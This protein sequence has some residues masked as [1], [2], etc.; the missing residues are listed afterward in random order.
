MKEKF[1]NIKFAQGTHAYLGN[2]E[3]LKKLLREEETPKLR[4]S[5][6][7]NG[8]HV[9]SSN[10]F[11][12]EMSP[13]NAFSDVEDASATFHSI[14]S[15]GEKK[16]Q[17]STLASTPLNVVE[18]SLNRS[19]LMSPPR[20]KSFSTTIS[21][22]EG[23]MVDY[24][25]SPFEEQLPREQNIKWAG[26]TA[27]Q[28]KRTTFE[29]NLHSPH[30]RD[31]D[32]TATSLEYSSSERQE[33]P[34]GNNND[35]ELD[36]LVSNPIALDDEWKCIAQNGENTANLAQILAWFSSKFARIYNHGTSV[37]KAFQLVV[38]NIG[39]DNKHLIPRRAFKRLLTAII[40]IHRSLKIFSS[41]APGSNG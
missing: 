30:S 35:L 33:S 6:V 41:L 15:N 37:C 19:R 1:D 34:N 4:D 23:Y 31:G 39:G 8:T 21:N 18:L 20:T 16:I 10:D 38:S 9:H 3:T 25:S 24:R 14:E 11:I 28:V 36:F 17:Q 22:R 12:H 29:H 2:A 32:N 27:P 13:A 5:E 26:R 40:C 7:W